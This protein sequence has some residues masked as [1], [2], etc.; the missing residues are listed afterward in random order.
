MEIDPRLQGAL[1]L[2]A[3]CCGVLLGAFW[4]LLHA[5]KILLGAY[6]P[7]DFMEARYRHPLP[8]LGRSVPF[9]SQGVGRGV[10]RGAVT[11]VF[12]LLFCLCFGIAVVLLLYAYNDGAIRL[13]VPVL[14]LL[15]FGLFHWA[16]VRGLS[17]PVAYFAYGFA[18]LSLYLWALLTLPVRGSRALCVIAVY[19]PLVRCFSACQRRIRHRRSRALCAAQL[20]WAEIGLAGGAPP[21]ALKMKGRCKNVE[22]KIRCKDHDLSMGDPHSDP[23]DLCGGTDHRCQSLD[24]VESAPPARG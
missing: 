21:R 15:G 16:A 10:W 3:L 22:K 6:R 4:E 1:F 11:A 20:R 12:D 2:G 24:G 8:L 7:P 17:L 18:A 9:R 14:A 5:V 23:C 13:S 19:R